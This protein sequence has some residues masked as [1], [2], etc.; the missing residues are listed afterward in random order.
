MKP[1]I[2]KV[3]KL[4]NIPEEGEWAFLRDWVT[5]LG[6]DTLE[7][8]SPR[9]IRDAKV[10]QARASLTQALGRYIRE[11]YEPLFPPKRPKKIKQDPYKVWTA[12]SQRDIDSAK[13]YILG[14]FPSHQS[15]D[16]GHGDGDVVQLIKVPNKNRD[17]E[18]SL[19]PHVSR[20]E[21]SLMPES[22]RC[23][24]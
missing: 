11:Q 14:A 7:V 6:P 17:W 2:D 13:S 4:K 19:T 10:G 21:I 8:V 9:G 24:R 5:P 18:K 15:G 16:D 1:F 23:I 22:V 20:L 12:S 3:A